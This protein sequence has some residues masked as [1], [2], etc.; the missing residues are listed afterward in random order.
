MY[1]SV[2]YAVK[3]ST[4]ST[5]LFSSSTGLKQGCNMSPSLFKVFINDIPELLETA[6]NDPVHLGNTKINCLLYADDLV[7]L[8]QS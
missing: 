3:L 8:S 2:K 4:G 5:P 7:L 6:N 1:S